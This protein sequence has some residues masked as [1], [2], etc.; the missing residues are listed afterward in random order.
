MNC[1]HNSE[2]KTHKEVFKYLIKTTTKTKKV[3]IVFFVKKKEPY[4]KRDI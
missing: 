3:I 1:W 4:H 2:K